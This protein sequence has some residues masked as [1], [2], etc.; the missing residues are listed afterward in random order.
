[1]DKEIA[2]LIPCFNEEK[3]IAE[4]I[5]D[6]KKEIPDAKIYV[7]D[8]NSTDKTTEI[9]LANDAIVKKE[10]KQGKGNV[11]RSMFRD[12]EADIY[13]MV[14]GDGTYPSSYVHKLI[15]PIINENMDMV[16]GD[17]LSNES[18]RKENKRLF[19]NFGNNFVRSIINKLFKS[20]LKDVMTGYRAFSRYFVKN[21]PVL[22]KGFEIE[23]EMTLHTLDKS[24]NIK[25]IPIE[26]KDRPEGSYSKLNTYKDGIKI[27][28]TIMWIFKDY[29]PFMFFSF[30][31]AIFFILSIAI[32]ISPIIEFIRYN[33][34][35]K[36]PSTILAA[37]LMLFSII[38]FT[39]GLILD[40]VSRF[41]KID[42]EL[43]LNNYNKK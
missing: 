27:V 36:V 9:A 11:V 14:D 34:I 41:H 42:Y 37:G 26:Y 33:Y 25:E 24:F 2:I 3:T 28:K 32:G 23:V 5:Y 31:A 40:T 29:K 4:V 15:D 20:S 39:I 10:C 30:L 35:Y 8:N 13:V 7:Y 21:M 43:K 22:S 6:F 17:R 1:M 16:V 19:H 38:F 12:I 18:Y